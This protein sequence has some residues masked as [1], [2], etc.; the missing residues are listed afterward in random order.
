MPNASEPEPA[1]PAGCCGLI[2]L[3]AIILTITGSVYFATGNAFERTVH[4]GIIIKRY[5]SLRDTITRASQAMLHGESTSWQADDKEGYISG[6][7]HQS[8]FTEYYVNALISYSSTNKYGATFYKNCSMT[9][10][11]YDDGYSAAASLAK[12]PLGKQK[13][14]HVSK[15]HHSKYCIDKH[16]FN[17]YHNTG[18]GLMLTGCGLL[19]LAVGAICLC[20]C[21]EAGGTRGPT[22][23]EIHY[24]HV[25]SCTGETNADSSDSAERGL[26]ISAHYDPAHG[27]A[28]SMGS[29]RPSVPTSAENAEIEM[30]Q[31]LVLAGTPTESATRATGVYSAAVTDAYQK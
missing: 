13:E 20:T 29:S 25:S 12:V 19:V 22:S 27:K 16:G 7:S 5:V 8:R 30:A 6:S 3:V 24:T 4:T 2:I 18:L 9:V 28:H 31:M 23:N 26:A 11:R 15:H 21:A 17:Y 1:P 10:A 14:V